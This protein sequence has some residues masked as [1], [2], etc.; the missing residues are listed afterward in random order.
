MKP[1][2]RRPSLG[3]ALGGG[4]A[5]GLA[6]IGILKVLEQENI[7]IDCMSGTSMG[8]IITAAYAVGHS[9]DDLKVEAIKTGQL[10]F[11][12]KLVDWE[13][14]VTGLLAGPRI[15]EYLAKQL[16]KDTTFE[17]LPIP[18]ALTAVDVYTAKEIVFSS[19]N[20]I[21]GVRATMALPGVV[22]PLQKEGQ[23]LVDGGVLNNVPADL[24]RKM[25]A[26]I[27]IAVDVSPDIH[28]QSVWDNIGMPKFALHKW[29]TSTITIAALTEANL[30]Q[31]KPEL[32]LRPKNPPGVTTITGFKHA[33]EIIT[34]GE[35]AAREALPQIRQLT[36][37]TLH[38]Q[39]K[40]PH[41]LT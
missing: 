36:K 30:H 33:P 1:H 28:D 16:G 26:E 31:A 39:D 8:G 4:G 2:F 40:M 11:M 14:P 5:R 25:G 34:A 12:L 37:S 32:I 20:L 22:E 27:V 18:I 38:F 6:H 13:L 7:P 24:V 10:P 41:R 9:M 19:G 21:Y 17:S 35:N 29:R 23:L 15:E 3:L